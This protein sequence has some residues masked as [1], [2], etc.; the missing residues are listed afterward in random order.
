MDYA[1]ETEE[2]LEQYVGAIQQMDAVK[3]F[4]HVPFFLPVTEG[5]SY[6]YNFNSTAV[7][8]PFPVRGRY[9]LSLPALFKISP[10]VKQNRKQPYLTIYILKIFSPLMQKIIRG[11]K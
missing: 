10:L 8:K 11:K 7:I 1:R 3:D 2:T 9:L 4:S 5:Y 6:L